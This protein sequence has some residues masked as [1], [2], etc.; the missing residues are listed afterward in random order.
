MTETALIRQDELEAGAFNPE[1]MLAEL[2]RVT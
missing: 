2:G 1:R